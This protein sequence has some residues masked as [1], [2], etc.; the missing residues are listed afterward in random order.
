VHRQQH[1]PPGHTVQQMESPS[2]PILIRLSSCLSSG[3]A[4]MTLASA[5]SLPV[6]GLQHLDPGHA[7][8]DATCACLLTALAL[9]QHNVSSTKRTHQHRTM[10]KVQADI[11]LSTMNMH[12]HR[13]ATPDG[14]TAHAK[15]GPDQDDSI[16]CGCHSIQCI[17]LQCN[18]RQTRH[19]TAQDSTVPT[20][21]Y[22]RT[23]TS[24]NL[25]GK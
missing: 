15:T 14:A 5:G 3:K 17:A 11:I 9:H 1:S 6:V 4:P 12:R 13:G 10:P 23:L 18:A 7:Y 16:T 22:I 20:S 19:C 24:S 8:R 2:H 21:R 25:H